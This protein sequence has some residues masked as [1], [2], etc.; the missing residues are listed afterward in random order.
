[1][2][3]NGTVQVRCSYRTV[4][5]SQAQISRRERIAFLASGSLAL[6]PLDSSQVSIG[7]RRQLYFGQKCHAGDP[8][9]RDQNRWP[10][11]ETRGGGRMTLAIQLMCCVPPKLIESGA[12]GLFVS[13]V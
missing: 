6:G 7:G 4:N 10:P 1:M 8:K 5:R 11:I 2:Y 13:A 12:I 3:G 9:R